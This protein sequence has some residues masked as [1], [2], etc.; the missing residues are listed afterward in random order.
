MRLRAIFRYVRL[1][2]M[3][4]FVS[5][6]PRDTN[7]RLEAPPSLQS[8][9]DRLG[10]AISA[11][12][13]AIRIG[14]QYWFAQWAR[15]IKSRRKFDPRLKASRLQHGSVIRV[16]FGCNVGD[17]LMGRHWG[18][19]LDVAN[20]AASGTV[21]VIPLSSEKAD[22]PWQRARVTELQLGEILPGSSRSSRALFGQIRA[23]SKQRIDFTRIHALPETLMQQIEQRLIG[24]YTRTGV[25]AEAA[26]ASSRNHDHEPRT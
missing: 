25:H 3:M 15:Y 7:Q 14:Y 16:D 26:A 2:L 17:E 24:L 1:V 11:E 18:V 21:L 8:S 22:R 9:L 12:P 5:V 20:A 19:V 23:V 4:L 10:S 13:D 6:G